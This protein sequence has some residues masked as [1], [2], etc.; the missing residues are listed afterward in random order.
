M[1]EAEQV[2]AEIGALIVS[3]KAYASQRELL[4]GLN[5]LRQ[6]NRLGRVQAEGFDPFWAVTTHADIVE[7]SRR[8]DLF[9]NGS[10]STTLVPRATDELARSACRRRSGR[11]SAMRCRPL[12]RPKLPSWAPGYDYELSVWQAPDTRTS[13]GGITVLIKSRYPDDKHPLKDEPAFGT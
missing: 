6:N 7:V 12:R 13:R 10:R 5:W 1:S 3:P 9:N 8:H 4:A 2:P 11:S